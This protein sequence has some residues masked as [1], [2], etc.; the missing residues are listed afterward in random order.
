MPPV[1]IWID[2]LIQSCTYMTMA[3]GMV[4][5]IP[6]VTDDGDMKTLGKAFNIKVWGIL[7]LLKLMHDCDHVDNTELNAIVGYLEYTNDLPYG[8]FMKDFKKNFDSS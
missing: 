2:G 3:F 7:D 8:D 5:D 1:G 6:V 4:L